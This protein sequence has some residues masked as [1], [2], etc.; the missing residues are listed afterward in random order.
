[1][2]SG[3]FDIKQTLGL[4]M[5]NAWGFSMRRLLGALVAVALFSSAA[6]AQQADKLPSYQI[7]LSQT[8]VSGLSSGAFMAAQFQVAFSGTLVGAGIIAGG[9]FYCV[10]PW[11]YPLSV[12]VATGIC[13]QATSYWKPDAA[14]LLSSAN[15]FAQ[16]GLIDDPA[17]LKRQKV[18]LFSGTQDTTVMESDVAQAAEFYRL[19]GVPASSINYVHN[20]AAGH[21]ILTNH[22]GDVAC[23]KTS[24]PFINDCNFMQSQAIL[25]YIYGKLNPPSKVL[26][27]K[28]IAFNQREFVHSPIASMGD[29]GYAYI[30]KSCETQSCRTHV[31]FH[32]CQQGATAIGNLFYTTTGYNELADS[33]NIIVLYPQ[34]QATPPLRNPQGCWDFWGYSSPNPVFPNFYTQQAP[35]MAAVRAMLARLSEL[36]IQNVARSSAP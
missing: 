21:A 31:A 13:M 36:R 22:D 35:Q 33:N 10:G 8:S 25:S 32:G 23:P 3:T 14:L 16:S 9:P 28:I 24:T 2:P 29:N 5:T 15:Y 27:G 30:P 34:V 20:I 4:L 12:S 18:Y 17:N 26:T 7:D 6:S 11:S 19:A 1:M